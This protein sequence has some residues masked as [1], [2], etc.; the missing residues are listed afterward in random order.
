MN[1]MNERDSQQETKN[2]TSDYS[3]DGRKEERETMNNTNE[4][5]MTEKQI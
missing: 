3:E 1:N 5:E 2:K 4:N